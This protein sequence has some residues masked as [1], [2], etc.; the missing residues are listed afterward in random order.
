[1]AVEAVLGLQRGDEGKG[2]LVDMLAEDA[3]IVAR[4]NGGNNAGH[5]V[6][7]P[8]GNVFKLHLIPSGI[9]RDGIVNIVGRGA[10]L[11]ASKLP[12]E[13]DHVESKGVDVTKDNLRI[14]SLAKL[15]LPHHVEA[16]SIREAGAG[17]QG[18]TKSGIAQIYGDAAMRVALGAESIKNEPDRIFT[19]AR[20]GLLAQREVREAV[21]AKQKADNVPE[22]KQLRPIDEEA[23]AREYVEKAQEVGKFVTDTTYYL[24]GQLNRPR[25][26]KVI[27]EGAQ[28]FLLDKD[29][30][31]YPYVTSSS[32]TLGGVYTGLGVPHVD[33]VYGIAKAP[34]SHVGG[35]PFVTEELDDTVLGILHGDMSAIDAERGTTTG[36]TRRLGHLDLTGIVRAN[37]INRTDMFMLTKLDWLNRYADVE[38]YDRTIPV[39]VQY[40]RKGKKYSFAVDSARKLEECKPHYEYLPAW[41]E[42]IQDIRSFDDLPSRAKDFIDFVQSV[43]KMPVALIGV[44]PR[45]DQVIDRRLELDLM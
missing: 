41:T 40:E 4:F 36:R 33:E 34:Q 9:T 15:I 14:D 13:I 10:V 42:D 7:T 39:C 44:G 22:D 25:P 31:M 29:H 20:E 19:V 26:A 30:G 11:D 5:T 45:R 12:D 17:A 37:W 6:Q 23:V 27:A 1:M 38:K 21:I 2:A 24:Y 18:S 3:D 32:P 8:D 16:D 43:I 28:A 35:G